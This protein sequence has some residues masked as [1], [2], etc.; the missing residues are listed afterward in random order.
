MALFF[1]TITSF[2]ASLLTLFSGFGLGTILMPVAALFF[3]VATAV[4]LTAF[5]HLLNNLFKLSLMWRHVSW[6]VVLRFGMPAMVLAVPGAWLLAQFAAMPALYQYQL[7]G[8]SAEVTP[9]KLVA[10]LLLILFASV[11]WMPLFN[12]INLSMK[13]LPV[14]GAFSG[15]FGG[16]TGHQG[17]FRSLF[18]IRAGLDKNQFVAS[19]AAIASFVDIAR[20]IVYGLNI[21]LLL[22]GVDTTL[23][24]M[25]TLA[26]FT[27][28]W[29]GTIFLKKITITLIQKVVA[30]MLYLL[31]IL[32]VAGMI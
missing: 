32:L 4:A 25:A 27:G 12:R 3:P 26:S 11:E 29:L 7:A 23:L 2:A 18:L 28:V 13:W 6:P 14:G 30:V 8:V 31:G 19:N 21:H 17:A 1:L 5:V 22:A 16:L 10:G 24:V 9:L 15:F 20:L